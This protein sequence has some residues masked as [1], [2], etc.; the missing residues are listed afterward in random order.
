[1]DLF[2]SG[3]SCILISVALLS[4]CSSPKKVVAKVDIVEPP[5]PAVDTPVVLPDHAKT[6]TF[7]QNLLK[8]NPALFD[9]VTAHK[10][11]WNVQF[12]YTSIDR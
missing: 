9:S 2:R 7:L 6:D 8:E 10:K 12:I 5:A 11:D 4:A 3:C 1:M